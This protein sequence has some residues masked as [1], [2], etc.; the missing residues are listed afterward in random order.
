[1]RL[2]NEV[3]LSV[4]THPIPSVAMDDYATLCRPGARRLG[5]PRSLRS[6]LGPKVSRRA[7]YL[8][9][10][11]AVL[12]LLAALHVNP[13]EGR[14]QA[15]YT[16]QVPILIEFL[17][18]RAPSG[19]A[20]EGQ[21]P[22][23]HLVPDPSAIDQ[24]GLI[25]EGDKVTLA[26]SPLPG[27]VRIGS[28]SDKWQT[29]AGRECSGGFMGLFQDCHD[30]FVDSDCPMNYDQAP[31][32][33]PVALKVEFLA[34]AT[35]TPRNTV[36]LANGVASASYTADGPRRLA[37]SGSFDRE[38]LKCPNPGQK[39]SGPITKGTVMGDGQPE[40]WF[41]V[42]VTVEQPTLDQ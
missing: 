21:R 1:M 23:W 34:E 3:H 41:T 35:N 4:W 2:A 10:F 8:P 27:E 17:G 26:V 36:T 28:W 20:L 39:R 33:T 5:G 24:I 31:L 7:P 42:T 12:A 25:R 14:A 30:T 32:Q 40:I 19:N 15:R 37:V 22:S 11:A 9:S 18:P 6:G 13:S 29:K 16:A 38:P